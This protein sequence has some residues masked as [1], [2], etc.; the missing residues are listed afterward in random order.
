MKK[1]SIKQL[2]II[3]I[4]GLVVVTGAQFAVMATS[5][6]G[7]GSF[8]KSR[9][10]YTVEGEYS[11][12]DIEKMIEMHGSKDSMGGRSGVSGRR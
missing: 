1:L 5:D 10:E 9:Q 6:T 3:F 11:E 8:D 12:D 7:R 2:V 4:A